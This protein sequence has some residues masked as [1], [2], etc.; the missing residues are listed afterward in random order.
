MLTWSGTKLGA[1]QGAWPSNRWAWPRTS[2]RGSGSKAA[3]I[4]QLC[5]SLQ[6]NLTT[7]QNDNT[8]SFCASHY[9]RRGRCDHAIDI[10]YTGV[11]YSTH[12]PH[13]SL[14]ADCFGVISVWLLRLVGEEDTGNHPPARGSLPGADSDN[15]VSIPSSGLHALCSATSSS[16]HGVATSP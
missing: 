16:L 15:A 12:K 9:N 10:V 3:G 4:Q 2:T 7:R 1:V 14:G 8:S 5:G 6:E 13:D 11:D